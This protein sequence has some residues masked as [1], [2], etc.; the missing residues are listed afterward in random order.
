[1]NENIGHHNLSQDNVTVIRGVGG[2]KAIGDCGIYFP[3]F[4]QV[5]Q[6]YYLKEFAD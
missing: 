6:G 3:E 4:G 1:M 5:K 2:F